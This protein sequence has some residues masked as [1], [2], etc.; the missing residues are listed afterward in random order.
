MKKLICYCNKVSEQ[1]IKD[2]IVKNAKTL[3]DI[4]ELTNACTGGNCA[5][6]NPFGKCCSTDIKVLL[7]REK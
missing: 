2:A 3:K 6:L 4:Q 1:E 7:R 5:E